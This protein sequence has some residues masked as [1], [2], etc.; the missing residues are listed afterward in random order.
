MSDDILLF[1]GIVNDLF[2][3][4]KVPSLNYGEFEA[5]IKTLLKQKGL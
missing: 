3:G 4:V 5:E 2:P 1:R